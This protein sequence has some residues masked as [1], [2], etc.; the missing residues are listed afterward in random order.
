LA[1]LFSIQTAK[2]LTSEQG[3]EWLELASQFAVSPSSHLADVERLR[4][5]LAP[6]ESAAVLEQVQLRAKAKRRFPNADRML[7]TDAGLQQATHP[8]V[9]AY[10]AQRYAGW[11]VVGDMGCGIGSDTIALSRVAERVV[12][13]DR[14][15]VRLCF[16]NHNACA[17]S[18]RANTHFAWADARRPPFPV[19]NAALFF[20]PSRRTA[21]GKRIY[22]PQAYEP[23]LA[24]LH[25]IFGAAE[26]LGIKV[27]PGMSFADVPWAE[28]IE[29]TSFA[30]EVKEAV[31][32][33]GALATPGIHRRATVLPDG[34]SVTDGESCPECPV[35]PPGRFIYEPD[36]AV[37]RAG[38]VQQIGNTL[39]LWQLDR[40]IAYL[41]GDTW[42]SSPFVQGF[43]I[44][45]HLPF[46]LKGIRRRLREHGVG[47]LEIKKRGVNLDP[48]AFRRRLRLNGQ[49][50]RTLIVTRIGDK[51][52][53]FL[54]R[55]TRTGSPH[56]A[57]RER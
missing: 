51:P 50:S 37:I 21:S 15:P 1:F 41:S 44:D 56:L 46:N 4:R 12:G 9:A 24:H 27:A 34:D 28:E 20:D 33:C 38:L 17:D 53:A 23:P 13:V 6:D 22:Q 48:D 45:E 5:Y 47:V 36:G 55:R 52:I 14:D 16:A 40:R 29:V 2:F 49:E 32:W 10:R 30:G 19:Y 11:K 25:R 31:L 35:R 8:A 57:S 42:R 18:D 39:D 43:E 7:F 3:R 54:C 26:A